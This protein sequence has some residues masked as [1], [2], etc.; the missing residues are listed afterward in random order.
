MAVLTTQTRN[1]LATSA[2]ALAGRRY[3]IHDAAHA[4]AALSRVAANGTSQEQA[5]VRAKVKARYP[6]MRI[7]AGIARD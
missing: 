7:D 2:F 5:I 1:N 6:G 4:K 3:P